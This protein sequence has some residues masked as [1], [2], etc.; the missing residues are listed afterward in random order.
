M[1]VDD[2]CELDVFNEFVLPHARLIYDSAFRLCGNHDDAEDLL[3]ETLFY[4]VKSFAQLKDRD[5][6]KYWLFSILKNLFL[7]QVEKGKKRTDLEFDLFSDNICD[8]SY[9]ENEYLRD[10]VERN[11]R[12][13]LERLD[14][15]LKI[16][17]FM[18]Y[19]DRLTYKEIAD[20][21]G[22]PIGTVMSRIARG[23]VYL[24]RE[25]IRSEYFRSEIMV[26]LEKNSLSRKAQ[27]ND[28]F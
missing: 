6:C 5:K 1:V 27:I 12:D 28:H 25:L 2:P 3:Q 18:F 4:A 21:L 7:K 26:W 19:F 16:P 24:K 23:K 11:L 8:V 17:I 20:I 10:E 9:I 14:E 22:V 13:I 15:R